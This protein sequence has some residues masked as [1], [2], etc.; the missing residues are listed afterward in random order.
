MKMKKYI[1][2]SML[3]AAALATA[4]AVDPTEE[5]D[6]ALDRVMKAWIRVNH[7][8]LSTYGDSGAYVLE[9]ET[10]NGQ[11]IGDSAYVWAHYTKRKLDGTVLSTNVRQ[12]SEQIGEYTVRTDYG[13]DI[14]RVDQGYLPIGL[15]KVLKTMRA[16]GHASIALPKSAS[17]HDNALYS[18][19]NNY[20]ENYNELID[21][22]I[23]TVVTDIT[24]YQD[25]TM[26]SWFREHYA[27]SDTLFDG[28]YFKKLVEKTAESD[29]ISEGNTAHVRY[30][31]RLMDGRVFDTNIEDT[32]KFYRLWTNGATYDALDVQYYKTDDSKMSSENSV[33]TGFARA[34]CQMNYG[35][36]A[37]TLFRSDLGYGDK[38]SSPS[39]PEYSPLVFWL[40]VEPQE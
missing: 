28:L 1:L 15:E 36:T 24:D 39:I 26:K 25:R 19:F 16:G 3:L 11:A 37:V 14:W 31:G 29:T 22:A 30:I 27:V 32:A 9:M 10:G 23:D 18:A 12:I 7:P 40:Y 33:V 2:L 34:V 38:G 5:D 6:Y 13:S 35:E 8:G 4:C 21:V 17:S 20:N